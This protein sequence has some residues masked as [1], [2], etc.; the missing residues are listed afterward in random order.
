MDEFTPVETFPETSL[1]FEGGEREFRS[2]LL[3]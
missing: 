3:R 2:T 1:L